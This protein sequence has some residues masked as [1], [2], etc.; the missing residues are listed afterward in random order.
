MGRQKH[1]YK[2]RQELKGLKGWEKK[3]LLNS[4]KYGHIKELK[5]YTPKRERG[6]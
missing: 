4:E 1:N 3:Y 5:V 6:K 2:G